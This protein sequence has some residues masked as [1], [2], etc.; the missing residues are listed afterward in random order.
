MSEKPKILV[1]DDLADMR[2]VLGMTLR[3]SNWDVVEAEDGL[4]AITLAQ[5]E[6][7]DVILMDYNMPNMNG[8]DSCRYI[9]NDPELNSIPVVIYTGA[10]ATDVREAAVTAG[11]DHFLT[12]PILP[13]DL[14]ATIDMAYQQARKAYQG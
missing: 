9:K 7:P 1:V 12:K 8:I 5:Q 4:E 14:R 3:R 11:A 6:R 13:S 10:Y 2:M